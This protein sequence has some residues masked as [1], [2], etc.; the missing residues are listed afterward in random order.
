MQDKIKKILY[1]IVDSKPS[2]YQNYGKMA[3]DF[4]KK[5]EQILELL[6]KEDK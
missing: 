3:K 4:K 5:A 1:S 2:N 6:N